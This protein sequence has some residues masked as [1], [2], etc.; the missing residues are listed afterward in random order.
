MR[1]TGIIRVVLLCLTLALATAVGDAAGK[2]AKPMPPFGFTGP[3][4]YKVTWATDSLAI[5]D[6][7]GDK[8]N[9]IVA[10]ENAFA[11]IQRFIQRKDPSKKPDRPVSLNVNELPED[12]RFEKRRYLAGKRVYSLALGDVN[13]DGLK[14]V[15]FYGD[16]PQLV[17]L[18]Q[19]KKGEWGEKRTFDIRDGSRRPNNLICA[20]FNGDGLHD[21]CLLGKDSTYFIYQK[22]DHTLGRP[23][24]YPGIPEGVFAMSAGD[25]DGDGR[26]DLLY[27]AGKEI[28]PFAIRLQDAKGRMSPEIPFKKPHIRAMISGDLDMDGRDEILAIEQ[29]TGRLVVYKMTRGA[30]SKGLLKGQQRRYPLPATG[31]SQARSLALVDLDGD[32]RL[33]VVM[34]NPKSAELEWLRQDMSG[35]LLRPKRFPTLQNAADIKAADLD[36]DGA[37]ELLILSPDEQTLGVARRLGSGRIGFPS[38]IATEGKPTAIAVGDLDGDG[39]PELI[40]ASTA[41]Y[42]RTLIVLK[43]LGGSRF[44]TWASIPLTNA[45]SD[46]EGALVADAN[47]DG[48]PDILVFQPYTGMSVIVQK[49]PGKFADVSGGARYGSGLAGKLN[50]AAVSLG[51]VTGDGKPEILIARGNFAR[52]L[53]LDAAGSLQVVDQFNARSPN[54]RVQAVAVADLNGDH[55]NEVILLDTFARVLTVLERQRLGT[56]AIVENVPVGKIDIQRMILCD[57]DR[58]GAADVLLFGRNKLTILQSRA[59]RYELK[60]IADYEA[61]DRRAVLADVALGDLNNDGRPDVALNETHRNAL[62]FLTYDA[63]TR[64]FAARLKFQVFEKKSFR[65][66][67]GGSARGIQPRIIEIADVTGDGKNDLILLIHDRLNIYPQD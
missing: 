52:A 48:R 62:H 55:V 22:P 49:T 61:R 8:L 53:R 38:R 19:N 26:T 57:F 18:F 31:S 16:P 41:K 60:E 3:E 2:G 65:R 13:G 30:P 21:I 24:K 64:R 4:M 58:D 39:K 25:F 43:C 23:V 34:T 15:V 33:D 45:R 56:Y 6:V 67:R 14:D 37:P 35:A 9:D 51:D 29:Q 54:S 27:S 66:G 36:G 7:N 47:Q 1:K 59:P 17:V 28:T 50:P 5:G 40:Y 42:K 46:V 10:P 20:D 63:K 12:T 44:K 11:R 32:Q